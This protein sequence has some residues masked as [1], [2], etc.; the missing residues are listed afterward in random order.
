MAKIKIEGSMKLSDGCRIKVL[1]RF[2]EDFP[3]VKDC[4][5][6]PRQVIDREGPFDLAL[7]DFADQILAAAL[8]ETPSPAVRNQAKRARKAIRDFAGVEHDDLE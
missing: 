3:V 5:G 7:I 1:N 6:K 2:D 8:D 4:P